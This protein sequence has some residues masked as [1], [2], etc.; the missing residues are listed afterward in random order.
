MSTM[1]V[2]AYGIGTI[3]GIVLLGVIVFWFI[4]DITQKKHKIGRAHV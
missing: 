1:G 2:L 3:L 4:Q